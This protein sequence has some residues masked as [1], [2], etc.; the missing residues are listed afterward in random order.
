MSELRIILLLIRRRK[1]AFEVSCVAGVH[2][3]RVGKSSKRDDRMVAL[4]P[5]VKLLSW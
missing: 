3:T 1:E 2:N 4:R 5:Y